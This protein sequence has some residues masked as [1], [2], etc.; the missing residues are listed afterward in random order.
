M[1]T[2]E[3]SRDRRGR[4]STIVASRLPVQHWHGAIGDRALADA[5]LDSPTRNARRHA[6]HGDN[7]NARPKRET[8]LSRK[9]EPVSGNMSF[10]LPAIA[11]NGCPR[12][13]GTRAR[14]RVQSAHTL[15]GVRSLL[16]PVRES[17]GT[18]APACDGPA[19]EIPAR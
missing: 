2:P 17:A 16:R 8:R 5:I 18:I 12:C 9:I 3:P 1:R 11:S 6:L 7:E 15:P 13:S 19:K 14:D 4:S 10:W